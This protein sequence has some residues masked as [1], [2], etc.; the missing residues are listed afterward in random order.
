[1]LSINSERKETATGCCSS[2]HVGKLSAEA[3]Q[4]RQLGIRQGHDA[5]TLTWKQIGP[6]IVC[7]LPFGV[8]GRT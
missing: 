1:M 8:R 2:L 7:A 6:N 5:N 4:Q 3:E